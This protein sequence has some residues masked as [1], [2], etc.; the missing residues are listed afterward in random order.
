MKPEDAFRD[1]IVLPNL[2][3]FGYVRRVENSVGND[4]ADLACCLRL[5]RQ[6]PGVSSWIELKHAHGWPARPGT[7]L[8]FGYFTVGQGN[9]L[10]DW[11]TAGCRTCVLAQVG[12]HYFL[13]AGTL[14]RDLQR[15]MTRAD[16][17]SRAA[18]VG[19]GVFPTGRIVRWLTER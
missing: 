6:G 19:Q 3:P 7:P 12:D 8:R 18:V 4:M 1:R 2:R 17:V 9:W 5:Q 15:G 11:Y 14:G 10:A 16:I 13:M